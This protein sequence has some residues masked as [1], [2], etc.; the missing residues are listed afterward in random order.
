MADVLLPPWIIPEVESQEWLDE[1]SS[2]FQAA[3][4]PGLAQRQSYGGMRL[5]LSR[6]HTVRA[7]EKAQLL[8][9]LNRTRGRYNA[10]RTKVH[11][12]LRGSFPATEVLSN[13]TFQNGTSGWTGTNATLAV[14]DRILRSSRSSSATNENDLSQAVTGLTQY[15]PYVARAYIGSLRNETAAVFFSSSPSFGSTPSATPGYAA[16]SA[17]LLQT[18]GS[19]FVY[20]Q[21]ATGPLAGDFFDAQWTSLSRCAHVDGRPNYLVRSDEFDN[22]SWTKTRSSASANATVAPNGTA[23]AERLIE[24]S[25]ASNSHFAIQAVS[26]SSSTLDYA[27]TIALKAGSRS[28]A[29]VA[30][31]ESTSGHE[32]RLWIDLSSGTIGTVTSTGANFT[33]L[34]SFVSPMGDGWYRVT[35]VAFKASAA[36]TLSAY[37]A[38]ATAD[39]SLT[40]S[41]DGASYISVWR[42]TVA[43]S[44]VPTA[45]APNGSAASPTGVAQ[46]GTAITLKGLPASTSGLLLPDDFFEINGELK[47]CTATLSS[48]ASQLGYLQFEPALVRSAA[49]NDPVVILDP[50]GKFLVSNIKVENRFGSQAIVTYDLEHIYE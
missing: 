42:A 48:D 12:A 21:A 22:A 9:V 34:R 17:V 20:G 4:A 10:L 30:L 14:A 27:F 23:T 16:A 45:L 18:T 35:L 38:L 32:A 44:S 1:G 8:A 2:V 37:V 49:D 28:R 26:V 24:D 3:F 11:F 46:T 39:A 29:V 41:G 6:R 7:E 43:Q 19:Y 40:Y 13:G 15:A 33:N 31:T 36:T 47:R 25:T 50:T 5:K